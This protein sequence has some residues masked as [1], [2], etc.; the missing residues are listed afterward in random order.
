MIARLRRAA[1]SGAAEL[2]TQRALIRPLTA[3]DVDA[4]L[5]LDALTAADYPGDIATS[6]EP[7][8]PASAA[9]SE[10]HRAWGAFDSEDELIGMTYMWPGP[11]VTE[12]DFTVV[13]PGWRRRGVATAL[14]AT[15]VLALID[16]GHATFRTGGSADNPAII[17]ADLALGYVVDEH[18]VTFA[19]P[20]GGL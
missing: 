20:E 11:D 14:K 19:P 7:L 10:R 8:T 6:H 18:W 2:G 9:P 5:R 1:K 16:E 12:T 13:H 17:R 15:A 4:V 3:S